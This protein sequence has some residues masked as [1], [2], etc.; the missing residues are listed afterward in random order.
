MQFEHLIEINS[1]TLPQ[2]CPLSRTTL[3]RGLV[4]RAEKPE[5]FVIGLDRC[6]LAPL[7][8]RHLRR[9]LSFGSYQVDD[10]VRLIPMDAVIY[11]VEPTATS[12]ASTLVMRI[13]EPAPG[14]LYLRFTYTSEPSEATADEFVQAH[15]KQAYAQAD[16]DTVKVIR[17]LAS[18]GLL[19][20]Q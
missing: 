18:Q 16:I 14:R 12:P 6:E 3:W 19:G 2:I 20:E 1:P 8:D 15:L 5:L 7:D 11:D 4:V 10:C 13:E 9:R 17:E